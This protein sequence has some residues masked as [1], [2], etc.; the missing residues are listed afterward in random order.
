[1]ARSAGV[2]AWRRR[3]EPE[4]VVGGV[5]C[6]AACCVLLGGWACRR[7]LRKS[8]TS[9]ALAAG[10]VEGGVGVVVWRL[11]EPVETVS[12]CAGCSRVGPSGP[13]GAVVGECCTP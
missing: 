13:V 12:P 8:G 11:G 5:C 10:S 3:W 9:G 6:V 7:W 1:M 2:G 4:W